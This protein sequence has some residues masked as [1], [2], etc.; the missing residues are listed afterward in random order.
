MSVQTQKSLKEIQ[1]NLLKDIKNTFDAINGPS[2]SDKGKKFNIEMME[3]CMEAEDQFKKS[4]I[5]YNNTIVDIFE[6]K[7][8]AELEMLR[9]EFGKYFQIRDGWNFDRQNSVYDSY[10]SLRNQV[11]ENGYLTEGTTGEVWFISKN[12]RHPNASD[13]TSGMAFLTL[14]FTFEM[15]ME[16]IVLENGKQVCYRKITNLKFSNS[17]FNLTPR[18]WTV[19]SDSIYDL[20]SDNQSIQSTLMYI[21]K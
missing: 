8:N 14:Y 3:A 2:S 19:T 9:A 10:E 6:E 7:F 11:R 15:D 13:K 18:E 17:R 4:V 20:I 12:K 5:A 16:S 21:C 1:L